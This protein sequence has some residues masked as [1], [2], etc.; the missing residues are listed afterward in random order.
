MPQRPNPV[1]PWEDF[2]LRLIGVFK[3]AKATLF[4]A[5]G[6]GLINLMHKNVAD[7][8]KTYIIDP[9][10]FD[11][12]NRLLKWLLDTASDLTDRKIEFVTFGAFF[13][14]AVFATEGIGLILRKHWAE[15]MVLISTGALL[16]VEIYEIAFEFAWW[17]V[18]I[19]SVN[20]AILI[21]LIHR[22]LLDSRSS[23]R[24]VNADEEARD[25]QAL[26]PLDHSEASDD[27]EKEFAAKE[28]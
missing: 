3:L 26:K 5:I 16:P 24:R 7:L 13:Y 2:V 11:P 19:M 20:V 15:Y 1:A 22:L 17:K 14:A 6:I 9:M 21:Y 4:I 8:L 10:H 27:G 12:E 25:D 28:P 23:L 18:V